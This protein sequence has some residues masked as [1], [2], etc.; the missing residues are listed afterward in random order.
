MSFVV[1]SIVEMSMNK[2]ALRI[3]V[4]ADDWPAE[5]AIITGMNMNDT[6]DPFIS[7]SIS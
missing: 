2:I 7:E 3:S 6:V 1:S 4:G 5:R